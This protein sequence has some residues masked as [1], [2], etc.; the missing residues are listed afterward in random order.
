MPDYNKESLELHRQ[1]SGKIEIV[2]KTKVLSTDDLS[3]VY[4]PGVAGPSLEI[5]RYPETVYDLTIKGNTVA[6]V[7]DGSAV[8]GLGNIGA[9][10]SLPVME[11]KCMLFKRF[12][13]INAFPICLNTQDSDEIVKTIKNIAPVFGG[14]NLEDIA[15]PRCFYIEK[16]LQDIGIPVFHDD[17]HG[18][19]IVVL[20][21]LINASKLLNK[22]IADMKV[23]ING[24]GAAGVAITKLLRCID[25]EDSECV[26]VKQILVCDSK[27]IISQERKDLSS[28]KKELLQYTNLRNISGRLEDALE[29]ADVFIG[30]SKGNLLTQNHIRSMAKNPVIFALA[31]PTPEI[32]PEEA[33][34]SGAAIVATGR[35]DYPNQ[36]NNVLAFPGIFRA[37]LDV[38]AKK[39]TPSMKIAAAY[40][41]AR[42]LKNPDFNH[43]I[44]SS[45]DKETALQVAHA[46]R[47]AYNKSNVV[48]HH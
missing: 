16:Q 28:E 21:G 19:A 32:F 46:V 41:L 27:G 29:N 15:A 38:R 30:V 12:A 17:Q 36:V 45:L 7:S 47:E 8:L 10:A 2:N 25:L 37:A 23:V 9:L 5:E 3:K 42:T 11:G 35:S 33:L 14:I 43:I 18:T 6:V 39:I 44:T 40:A 22:D 1:L 48:T 4:S 31:N 20:A 26:S 13:G 24:A 34:A